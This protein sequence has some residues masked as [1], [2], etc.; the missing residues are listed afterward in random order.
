MANF[1]LL[2]LVFPRQIFLQQ[3]L[4]SNVQIILETLTNQPLGWVFLLISIKHQNQHKCSVNQG[5]TEPK[6][7]L[8]KTQLSLQMLTVQVF[9]SAYAM[10]IPQWLKL[11][12]CFKSSTG[13]C[14][15]N[16]SLTIFS[17]FLSSFFFLMSLICFSLENKV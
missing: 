2:L 13:F 8:F 10:C 11:L 15:F 14:S 12:S 4:N 9:C 6:K 5:K 17:F 3:L 16:L 1:F 7:V